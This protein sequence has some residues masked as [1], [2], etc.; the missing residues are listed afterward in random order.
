MKLINIEYIKNKLGLSERPQ[1]V[2]PYEAPKGV[3]PLNETSAIAKDSNINY[4]Y[5]SFNNTQFFSS[6]LG[7]PAISALAQSSD[8]RMV[9]ETTSHEM[10]RAWGYVTGIEDNEKI[11]EIEEELTRIGV[12]ELFR[13]HIYNEQLFGLSHLFLDTSEND[14]SIPLLT[15][16][17][18]KGTR[19]SLKLIEP[20]HTTP[21]SYN[22]SDATQDDFYKVR[23]WF[24]LG[25]EINQDR[26]L[27]LVMRPVPDLFKPAYN[28]GGT[29]MVQLMQPYVQRWQRTVDSVSDL[30]KAFSITCLKTDMEALLN[31][32]DGD[33]VN[34]IKKRME[35]F[36][37]MRDNLDLMALGAEEELIQINTP[38]SGL[39]ALVSKSQ[40]QMSMPSH[41]PLVKLTGITPS[42]LNASSDGE[43]QVYYDWIMSLNT[44]HIL[45]Q[46][47]T[48]I[49]AV[50]MALYGEIDP[51]I[52]FK[53]NSLTQMSDKEK[54]EIEVNR[55]SA[56]AN[57]TTN[58]II[59][60]EE[61]GQ[62]LKADENLNYKSLDLD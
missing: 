45:P 28:F 59:S 18:K 46:M 24:A 42:G 4:A 60:Q 47:K 39:D 44:A 48:I 30:I 41:T 55:T 52:T 32:G 20:I 36:N 54:S 22:A 13:K 10:T 53:F 29:S 51:S 17:I 6:F 61:A 2:K 56:M 14:T 37:L 15:E 26:L 16:N 43:I 34:Q 8:Y 50:Q 11:A 3:V 38:L 58:G 33:G 57:L 12:R 62:L 40:E 5:S 27:T 35:L 21:A 7:Y 9:P 23:T 19:L 31:D 49:E 25:K 1:L